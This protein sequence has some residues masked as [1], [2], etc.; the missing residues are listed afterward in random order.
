MTDGE[1]DQLVNDAATTAER[2][3]EIEAGPFRRA[4]AARHAGSDGR[5][6]MIDPK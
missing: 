1:F 6:S 5:R 4:D 2:F 3:T